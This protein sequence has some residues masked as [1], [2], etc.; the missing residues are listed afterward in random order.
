MPDLH[1]VLRSLVELTSTG[2]A[3]SLDDALLLAVKELLPVDEVSL[4]HNIFTADGYEVIKVCKLGDA[5]LAELP[6][7][8]NCHACDIGIETCNREKACV[9]NLSD[10]RQSFT[11]PMAEARGD[12]IS[13]NLVAPE[14]DE[15]QRK[16]ICGVVRI[17]EN[18]R[19]IY[20]SGETDTLTGLLNRKSFE[21][22]ITSITEGNPNLQQIEIGKEV[23]HEVLND[24]RNKGGAG[25]Y[26]LG[27]IDIDRFKSINDNYGHLF[28]D[29]VLVLLAQ[30]MRKSFR[31]GDLLFR[32]GGEEFVVVLMPCSEE[33]AI[34]AFE[35][36]RAA[37]ESFPF[38]QV[39]R[40]TVS[41]GFT[42]MSTSVLLSDV[43]D[44]ADMALYYAKDHGRNQSCF[45]EQLLEQGR[46]E[47]VLP[48]A[49]D[50]EL[51]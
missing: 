50:I 9:K 32:Y 24:R 23:C 2:D 43:I 6:E 33:D 19:K 40:V 22:R 29:E 37:V 14:I 5:E 10:G 18:F 44:K 47:R 20:V 42:E 4:T 35:R 1:Q 46:I 15:D 3:A 25:R 17:F 38:P 45:Y 8:L 49:G 12:Y 26:W 30:I 13:F 39:D 51:F 28:G 16:L 11:I 36:F 34:A 27:V 21:Q 31:T 48:E 7:N 41:L